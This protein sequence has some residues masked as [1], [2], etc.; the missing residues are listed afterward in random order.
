MADH[1]EVE[2]MF[3]SYGY[4]YEDIQTEFYSFL[5][6]S[7]TYPEIYEMDEILDQYKFHD[8]T[9]SEYVFKTYGNNEKMYKLFQKMKKTSLPKLKK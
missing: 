1:P 9:Y 7:E 8:E 6:E 3:Y 2:Q 5:V 4:S